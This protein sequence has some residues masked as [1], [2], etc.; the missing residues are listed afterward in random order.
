MAEWILEKAGIPWRYCRGLV[1]PVLKPHGSINW[2]KHEEKGHRAE[3]AGIWQP[4]QSTSPFSYIPRNPFFDPFESGPNQ[5]LRHLIFP[6]ETESME[7]LGLKL[8]W[9]EVAK[10]ISERDTIAFIGYSL[11]TYDSAALK[12]LTTLVRGKRIEVYNPNSQH[13]ARF[14]EA[15]G[16]AVLLQPEKFQDS[17]YG[18]NELRG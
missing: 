10:I 2:S 3:T 12:F 9:E 7:R 6:G 13:L 1:V 11:P 15:F 5:D 17:F 18:T 16:E 8:L 14:R 4:I